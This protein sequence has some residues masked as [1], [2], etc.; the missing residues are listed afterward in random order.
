MFEN[1]A[2]KKIILIQFN[3]LACGAHIVLTAVNRNLKVNND[4]RQL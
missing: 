1:H 2:N 4:C 3:T